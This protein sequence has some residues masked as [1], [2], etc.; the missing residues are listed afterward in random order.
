MLKAITKLNATN[1]LLLFSF[2]IIIGSCKKTDKPNLSNLAGLTAFSIKDLPV[3]FAIDEASQKIY[4]ADSLPFKTDVSKLIAQ[5]TSVPKSVVKVG[6]TEQVPGT[7]ANNFSSPV[8]YTVVAEDGSTTRNYSVLVNVTKVDPKTISWQQLTADAGWGAFHSTSVTP[9][10]SK[11]YMI[12]GTMGAFGSF[13]FSSNTSEDGATWTRTRAVDNNG[14]SVP[15]I[16][17]PGFISFNNKLWIIGGHRPGVGFSFDDVTN[18][19]WSSSDGISWAASEPAAPEDRWV[20]RERTVTVVFKNQLWV[21]GGNDYPSFGN[22]NSPGTAYNDVWSSPDGTTWTVANANPAFIPRTNPAVFVYDD[23]MWIAGG[24]DNGGNY[25]DDVWNS[26]DGNNWTEVTTN[27]A[28]TG[29]IAPQ[30]VVIGDQLIMVGGENAEGV[31]GD[32]WISENKGVDWKKMESGDVRALPANFKGRKD[33]SMVVYKDAV[34]IIGGLGLKTGTTYA[35]YSDV[36]MGK[37]H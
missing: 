13:P 26:A 24:K 17:H 3:S 2:L 31:L 9:M 22:T 34:Y 5:F 23:K 18:K 36:W 30:V 20:K 16:E 35:T 10:G 1:A 14:D 7:T 15:R 28:F 11:L 32:M 21:I 6:G 37:L 25:L 27:T 12:G 29:R 8:T 4:N 33:F 19:V